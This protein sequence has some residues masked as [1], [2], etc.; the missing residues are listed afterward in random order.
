MF[1][2]NRIYILNLITWTKK[3]FTTIFM[4]QKTHFYI[5]SRDNNILTPFNAGKNPQNREYNILDSHNLSVYNL[6][7]NSH[8]PNHTIRHLLTIGFL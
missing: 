2:T 1:N 8:F 3:Y 4:V 5:L 6:Y 7:K